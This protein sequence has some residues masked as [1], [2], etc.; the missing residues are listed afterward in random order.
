MIDRNRRFIFIHIPKCGGTSLEDVVWP[1]PRR[2]EDLWGGFIDPWHNPYQTGGLQ[3]LTAAL[4]RQH[5]GAAEFDRCFRFAF[6]RNPFD[7]VL[8][9]Y[10]YMR[11]RADLREFIG[12]GVEDDLM[13]YLQRI[14]TRQHVQWMP[15]CDF[16]LDADGTCLVDHV[17]KLEQAAAGFAKVVAH[18]GLPPGT[19]L[20]HSNAHDGPRPDR[21]TLPYCQ[22]A[23]EAFPGVPIIGHIHG[24][25][26]DYDPGSGEICA[27]TE[28]PAG[29]G[30]VA[31]LMGTDVD[32]LKQTLTNLK[33]GNKGLAGEK[34]VT[35]ELARI[36]REL[37]ADFQLN[38]FRH[39][40]FYDPTAGRVEMHLVSKG[41]Q[42]VRVL[43]ETHRFDADE[44]IHTENSYKFT[45]EQVRAK[46]IATLLA[47]RQ[48][49]LA[50]ARQRLEAGEY[51]QCASCGEPIEL[52]RL[53]ALPTALRCIRC[54]SL[55]EEA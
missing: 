18:L 53:E 30:K 47:E 21:A 44:R 49:K 27:I 29:F 36:N 5:V 20:P 2:V 11:R 7:R 10:R 52:R 1:V 4:V 22:R 15:Q 50:R 23:R 46:A 16:L 6:V 48:V 17:A 8:S 41:A 40:A 13:T 45:D 37:G 14:Q 26:L 9:Q 43:D 12:M 3:H 39:K 31:V 51:G 25:E 42:A 55:A 28:V 38:R 19:R 34:I 32:L 33:K 35:E 54:Q 24:T